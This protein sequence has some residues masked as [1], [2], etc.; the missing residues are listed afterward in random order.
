MGSHRY[1]SF[2]FVILVCLLGSSQAYNFYVGG[3]D[4]WE[5]Q[6]SESYDHWAGRNRFQVND[7]SVISFLYIHIYLYM[8]MHLVC[9]FNEEP[10]KVL[11][12]KI[13]LFSKNHVSIIIFHFIFSFLAQIFTS[14]LIFH[15]S[16]SVFKYNKG[17]DSVL[18]V[19]KEDYQNCYKS[20]P[21]QTLD[22][23]DSVFKFDRSG[24]F[25]FISGYGDHC[26]KGQ[27][28]IVVVLAVRN[29]T[30]KSPTPSPLSPP[31]PAA[32]TPKAEAPMSA[33]APKG[34]HVGSAPAPAPVGCGGG[35]WFR[36]VRCG[37]ERG[38]GFVFWGLI[39]RV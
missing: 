31:S 19:A 27:K 16:L 8:Y 29:A 39:R 25:Y 3:K 9:R 18:V 1:L 24:P 26:E 28:L 33:D 17:S 12:K 2:V 13:I 15:F 20:N 36:R 7:S 5:L 37:F 38:F 6:P 34:S 23:G 11:D 4:G 22:G 21:I 14:Y 30:H 10:H 35:R 32:E